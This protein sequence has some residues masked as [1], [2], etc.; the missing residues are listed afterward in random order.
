VIVG[1]IVFLS[2]SAGVLV[3]AVLYSLSQDEMKA[4]FVFAFITC[5]FIGAAVGV[6]QL[7]SDEVRAKKAQLTN[8]EFQTKL[9]NAYKEK[10]SIDE[11]ITSYE[12]F[13]KAYNE[14]K[15]AAK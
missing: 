7:E 8:A 13:I 6:G 10:Y 9:I 2:L 12:N 11:D 3:L 14:I 1:L 5:F 4:S 15:E